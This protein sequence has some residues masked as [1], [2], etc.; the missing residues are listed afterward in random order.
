MAQEDIMKQIANRDAREYVRNRQ[1]FRGSNLFTDE[2]E[3]PHSML[4][5]V[6]S[7]GH[8]YP[9]F[10]A[11][12]DADNNTQWYENIDKYSRSTSKQKSQAHPYYDTIKLDINDMQR[13]AIDG[14][15]E[16]IARKLN[17]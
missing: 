11:E 15:T 4:Y 13:V 9:M 16:L 5:I 2:V 10:V 8:H 17:P 3:L 1:H 14:F 7:Y 6:Y 12:T